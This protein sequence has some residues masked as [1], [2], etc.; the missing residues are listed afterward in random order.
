MRVTD[1]MRYAALGRSNAAASE[2]VL[3]ASK[4]ASTGLRVNGPADDPGAFARISAK[5]GTISRL[6]G[7]KRSLDRSLGDAQV[8]ESA[9]AS[10]SDIMARAKELAVQMS[11]GSLNASQRAVA[12]SEVTQL[13]QALVAVANT[14][15]SSGYVFGGTK[16]N[17]APIDASGNFVGNDGS[18]DVEIGDGVRIRGNASGANAFTAA[19]G[20]DVLADLD[21]LANALT[22]NNLSAVQGSIDNL[23]KGFDQ[24]VHAR[25][26]IGIS[27]DRIHTASSVTDSM[28]TAVRQAKAPDAE[29]DATTAYT[30]LAEANSAYERSIAITQKMLST[31]SA[32]KF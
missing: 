4:Q 19:G 20:R 26:D 24:I 16:S 9:L 12:A 21:G 13:R 5:D 15:G 25:T 1:S 27:L 11:D 10:G 7:R 2:R 31:F 6:D 32:E 28:A 23:G 22:T 30:N 8:A 14:R 29:I 18:I 3:N 17:A